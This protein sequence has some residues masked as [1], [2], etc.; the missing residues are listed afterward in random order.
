MTPDEGLQHEWILE[1]NF[2]RVRPRTKPPAKKASG[3]STSKPGTSVRVRTIYLPC[4]LDIQGTV[5]FMNWII[6]IFK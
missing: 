2:N 1:G 3:S 6:A 5:H 4:M